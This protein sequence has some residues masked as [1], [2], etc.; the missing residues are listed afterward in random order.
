M[1]SDAEVGYAACM[2]ADSSPV[3]EGNF[4]AGTGA[5]IGKFFGLDYAM[6]SGVGRT[7]LTIRDSVTNATVTVGA[8]VAVNAMG[9]VYKND[10]LIAGARTLDGKHVRN[11]V[12]T[13]LGLGPS[14]YKVSFGTAT[15]LACVATDATLNKA[16]AKK[17]SQMAHDGYA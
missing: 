17:V 9:D 15:T 2:A 11:T 6:K 1:V 12:A 5:T 16:G 10:T 13:L 7:S 4:G 3:R 8:I 14:T